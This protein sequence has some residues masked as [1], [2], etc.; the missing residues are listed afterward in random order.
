M[1]MAGREWDDQT[2][3]EQPRTYTDMDGKAAMTPLPI[4]ISTMLHANIKIWLV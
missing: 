4:I 2:E 3:N 1:G